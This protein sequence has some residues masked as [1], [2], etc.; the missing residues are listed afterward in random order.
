VRIAALQIFH[1][2]KRRQTINISGKDID[3]SLWDSG[4][5][6]AGSSHNEHQQKTDGMKSFQ[7]LDLLR[8][9]SLQTL[10]WFRLLA[11]AKPIIAL[12]TGAFYI[13][14]SAFKKASG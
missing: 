4:R 7:H 10:P 11:P 13:G 2:T 3:F 9:L 1:L 6:Q 14:I 5:P 12:P 8:G